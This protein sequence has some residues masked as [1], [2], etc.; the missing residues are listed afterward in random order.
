MQ[1]NYGKG[2]NREDN[3]IKKERKVRKENFGQGKG[4]K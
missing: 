1:I 4:K 2:R 3:M